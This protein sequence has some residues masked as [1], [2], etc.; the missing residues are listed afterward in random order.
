MRYPLDTRGFVRPVSRASLARNPREAPF[1]RLGF[2]IGIC[3]LRIPA[4]DCIGETPESEESSHALHH[5]RRQGSAGGRQGRAEGQGH[6]LGLS[7]EGGGVGRRQARAR[8]APSRVRRR[9][10]HHQRQVQYREHLLRS[11]PFPS[12]TFFRVSTTLPQSF[13][14]VANSTGCQIFSLWDPL[15]YFEI[16][17]V[18]LNQNLFCVFVF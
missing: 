18:M 8:C 7:A 14:V 16:F 5:E 2:G 6:R 4:F 1:E 15:Y 17:W 3:D 12:F 10:R 9:H 11:R 13:R